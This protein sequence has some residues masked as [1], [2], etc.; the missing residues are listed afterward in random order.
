MNI[1]YRR[2]SVTFRNEGTFSLTSSVQEVHVIL[3]EILCRVSAK[4][5]VFCIPYVLLSK[6]A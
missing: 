4:K 5:S 2:K 1:L 6:L 3:N